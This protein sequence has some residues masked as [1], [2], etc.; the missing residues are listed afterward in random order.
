MQL[1]SL[2]ISLSV[3]L[4]VCKQPQSQVNKCVIDL[5]LAACFYVIS[6]EVINRSYIN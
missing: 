1:G 4:Y 2:S 5:G 3:R 6:N